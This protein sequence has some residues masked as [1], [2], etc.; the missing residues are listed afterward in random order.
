MTD[1]EKEAQA[2]DAAIVAWKKRT[3]IKAAWAKRD[4]IVA[5]RNRDRKGF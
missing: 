3:A 1:N 2:W 5:W 4:A